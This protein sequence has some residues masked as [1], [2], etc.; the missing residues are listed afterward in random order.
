[1]VHGSTF[2]LAHCQ[3]LRY[4]LTYAVWIL[5]K[6]KSSSSESWRVV[7]FA[8][9]GR[10]KLRAQI[11]F[12]A[13]HDYLWDVLCLYMASTAWFGLVRHSLPI[14]VHIAGRVLL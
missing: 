9:G 5:P 4:F 13:Q 12:S 11:F 2:S 1:M 7:P 8:L 3:L 10:K 6:E 14:H